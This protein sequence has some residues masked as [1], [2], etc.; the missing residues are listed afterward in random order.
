MTGNGDEPLLAYLTLFVA[1]FAQEKDPWNL[2]YT[3]T[4]IVAFFVI[5]LANNIIKG[6]GIPNYNTDAIKRGTLFMLIGIFFFS[7]GL[8]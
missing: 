2:A 1:I 4:P 7:R 6:K 8:D 5:G 3:V